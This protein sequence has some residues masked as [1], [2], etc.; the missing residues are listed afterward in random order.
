MRCK[1]RRYHAWCAALAF[2][3][4]PGYGLARRLRRRNP[5]G[6]CPGCGYD[7]RA[8]PGRCPGI[9]SER[10]NS[11]PVKRLRRIFLN[12][13]TALSLFLFAATVALWARS[14][15]QT[16]QLGRWRRWEDRSL[17]KEECWG[18]VSQDRAIVIV[19]RASSV[20]AS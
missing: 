8:T 14:H 3:A 19:S 6:H 13:L 15:S 12:V 11:R 5:P 18:L 16:D 7:L 2:A 17:F 1:C 20:W 10:Y 9:V 4:L